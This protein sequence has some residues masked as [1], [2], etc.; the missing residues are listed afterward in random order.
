MAVIVIKDLTEN[1]DLDREAMTRHSWR[2]PQRRCGGP[3]LAR[4]AAARPIP[5]G[6]LSAGLACEPACAPARAGGKQAAAQ[7]KR[8]AACSM[9]QKVESPPWHGGLVA[10][11]PDLLGQRHQQFGHF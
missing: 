5:P 4:A 6:H 9:P 8:C 3:G 10:D 7:V 11:G 1:I 2:Q